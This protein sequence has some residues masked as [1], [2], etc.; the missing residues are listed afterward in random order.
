[1]LNKLQLKNAGLD[2]IYD[3]EMRVARKEALQ[4]RPDKH[5]ALSFQELHARRLFLVDKG[6]LAGIHDG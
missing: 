3:D 6:P 4:R 1:M 5:S 2:I